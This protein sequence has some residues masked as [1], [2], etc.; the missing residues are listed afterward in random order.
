MKR[1]ILLIAAA[2][3]G[4]TVA[5][6]AMATPDVPVRA[7]CDKAW[8]VNP[9]EAAQKPE[10]TDDGLLFD[11]PKLI[12][13]ATRPLDLA[14]VRAG[15]FTT[16]GDVTGRR[17]LF[18]MET[19]TPYA[20]I[21][22]TGDGKFWSSKIAAGDTGGQSHPVDHAADLVGL[23]TIPGKTPLT[24]STHVVTFGVG[25]ANDTG[26]KALVTSVSFHGTTYGLGCTPKPEATPTATPKP[27]VPPTR[28]PAPRPSTSAVAAG[29][30][31]P[32]LPVTGPSGSLFVGVGAGVVLAG[33]ALFIV[34]RRRRNRFEA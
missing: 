10:Q 28:K 15:T 17:P 4:A 34:G 8:Y 7:L 23:P 32:S 1:L 29:A 19:D 3:L 6:P 2:L 25:Y 27:T 18:S 9:D 26:N 33:V 12:H 11:G 21:N 5:T 20:T 30:G 31:E 22:V 24:S 16:K 14:D 13:H